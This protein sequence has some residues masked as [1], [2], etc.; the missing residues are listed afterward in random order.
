MKK[1]TGSDSSMARIL[2]TGASGFIGRRLVPQLR[3]AGYEVIGVNSKHG[4]IADAS[5][6]VGFPR[7]EVVIHLAGKLFVP[8][9]WTEPGL[10]LN[11]NFMATVAALDYCRK[12]GT[13]LVF[14][15]SYL[16]GDP[17]QLPIPESASLVANNPYALSKKLAEEAAQFYSKSFDINVTILRP[18]NVYGPGQGE[19][20]LIPSIV[21]QVKRSREIRVKDLEPRRDYLYVTDVVR[22][23]VNAVPDQRGFS[24]YN[25][26]SGRSY[27]VAEVIQA[28]QHVWRTA[29][30]VLCE[31]ERRKD[32][33]MDTVADIAAAKQCLGWE[34]QFS[35]LEGIQD[36]FDNEESSES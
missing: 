26:G 32:E 16:Y 36:M 17:E 21:R 18:F 34:P 19:K 4:D 33:V 10:F 25:I 6:W 5:T 9:S 15:S 35:L 30:P 13:S 27:S 22:A 11:C 2:V 8:D 23:I 12:Y 14:L 1:S 7:A 28:I 24:V 3:N 20:F 29:L 31:G